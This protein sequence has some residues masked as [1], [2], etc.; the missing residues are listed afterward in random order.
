MVWFEYE[1]G[2]F[3]WGINTQLGNPPKERYA[4]SVIHRSE[5]ESL[6]LAELRLRKQAVQLGFR[7]S[8]GYDAVEIAFGNSDRAIEVQSV[9]LEQWPSQAMTSAGVDILSQD[10]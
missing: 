4:D 2:E 10:T 9:T 7:S 5:E 3:F 8:L 1:P 6:K